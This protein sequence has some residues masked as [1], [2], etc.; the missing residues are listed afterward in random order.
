MQITLRLV[1]EAD[2][3]FL[4]EL[5]ANTRQEE[6]S[7]VPWADE[8]KAEFLR[9]QF[10]AQKAGYGNTHPK[11]AHSIICTGA[12]RVGRLYIDRTADQIHILDVTVA[13]RFRNRGL[14]SQV[15]RDIL[16]EARSLNQK[17]TVY[18]ESFNPSLRLFER[19]GFR[20]AKVDGFQLLLE[21]SPGINARTAAAEHP[22]TD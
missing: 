8:Q 5:Y 20:T 7:Q 3:P 19:L 4:Y 9:M 10:Q 16:G 15:L 13:P 2:E 14:G 11:A 17:V 12:E 22:Q 1:E 6:L 18:V 21:H